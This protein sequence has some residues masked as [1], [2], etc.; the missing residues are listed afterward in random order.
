MKE[1]IYRC[2]AKTLEGFVQQLAV[3]YIVRGYY[4]YVTG[5]VPL[6]LSET[7]HDQRMLA[8]FG[9]ARSKWS[10]CRL[11][12]KRGPSGKPLANCQYIRLGRFWVLLCEEG[13]HAF[14]EVHSKRDRFGNVVE[15]RFLD[16]R[17]VAIKCGGYSIGYAG[18]RLCVRICGEQYQKLKSVYLAMALK[19][20]ELVEREFKRFPYASYGG[21]NKQAFAILKAVNRLRAAGNLKQIPKSCINTMLVPVKAFELPEPILQEPTEKELPIAA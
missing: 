2:E 1:Y 4:Y 7:D 9:V 20:Q 3:G 18:E 5:E 11:R 13:D 6:R 21:V 15:R 8:K 17:E 16:A 19:P 12:K 14:F 10:R